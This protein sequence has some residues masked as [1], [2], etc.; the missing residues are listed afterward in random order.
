MLGDRYIKI[1][2]L[3]ENKVTCVIVDYRISKESE[4]TL[5]D[6]NI[7]V[8]KTAKLNSLYQAVNGHPDMQIHHLGANLFVCEKTLLS[9]YKKLLPDAKIVSGNS[10]LSDKYPQDI[11]YNVARVG[12]FL[13]HYLNFTDSS[14]LEYYK[15]NGVKL[16]NVKQGYSKCSVCIINE[17]AIITSD[18]KIAEKAIENG[19]DAMFFDNRKILIKGLDHGFIGGICGLID[20]NLLAVNGNIEKLADFDKF[21]NFCQKHRTNVLR[22]NN[23]IPEDIGSI[24]PVKESLML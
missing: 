21:L 18:I 20:K 11:A 14:I 24:L 3:P 2:N 1:P 10:C 12:N 8:L 17:N 16:I 13:F 7:K 23:S 4:Q 15:T 5:I 6:N 22:L 19:V 9:Y